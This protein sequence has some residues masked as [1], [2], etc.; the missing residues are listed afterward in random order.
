MR[1]LLVFLFLITREGSAQIQARIDYVNQYKDI[2]ISEMK[3]TGVPASIKLAQG[4]LESLAGKSDLATQANNHFGI[5]CHKGWIGETYY[6][7]DDDDTTS[8]FRKY[9][10]AYESY[11][12]HSE[13]LRNRPRYASLFLLDPKDYKG[14]AKGLKQCGYATLPTYAEQLIRWIDTLQLYQYDLY[15]KEEIAY[16]KID[17]VKMEKDLAATPVEQRD[18]KVEEFTESQEIAVGTRVD[19]I[20]S[21]SDLENSIE[22][23]S[24]D[25]DGIF[26]INK[27]MACRAREGDTPLSIASRYD[28][29]VRRLISY[30]EISRSYKFEENDIVFLQPKKSK[31]KSGSTHHVIKSN[32]TVYEISQLYGVRAKYLYRYNHL[33]M[34]E[35]PKKGEKITLRAMNKNKVKLRTSDDEWNDK[36]ALEANSTK[37]KPISTRTHKIAKGDTLWGIAKKYEVSVQELRKINNLTVDDLKIGTVLKLN[38]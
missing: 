9:S 33:K 29:D 17:I 5:K 23:L 8:C 26:K 37:P 2:A 14:W 27:L 13:F 3:R 6:K 7:M 11:I 21:S 1:Y 22:L 38:N 30:N 18:T 28:I 10:S 24:V 12:E 25:E 36:K 32:E 16:Y 35:E 31:A 4:I 34:G 15:A 20:A 19:E